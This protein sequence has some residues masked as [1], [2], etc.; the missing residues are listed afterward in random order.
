[1]VDL[2]VSEGL[3]KPPS[4]TY[5]VASDVAELSG[6]FDGS[7]KIMTVM[8]IPVYVRDVSLP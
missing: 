2:V 4:G 5:S 1:M 8:D 7:E 6:L 3:G